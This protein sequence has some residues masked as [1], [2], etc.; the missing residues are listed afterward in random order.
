MKN[1][2]KFENLSLQLGSRKLF[3]LLNHSFEDKKITALLG[4]SGCGKSTWLKIIAG[5]ETRF[6]GRMINTAERI[7]FVFQEARLIPWLTVK[8]NI[9]LSLS[10]KNSEET[11]KQDAL[12]RVLR[13]VRLE[14]S[15]HLFPHQLSGGMKMRVS[16]ARALILQPDLVLFDEP[17]SALDEILKQKLQAE[18]RDLIRAENY[19]ALFVTHS[20]EE[21]VFLADEILILGP[22]SQIR[23]RHPVKLPGA[24]NHSLRSDQSYFQ[25]VNLVRKLLH[26]GQT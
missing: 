13:R 16:L 10:S 7:S 17:F 21:A 5:L 1:E 25:E 2:L 8:E 23:H 24:R 19:T 3:H 12:E 15:G 11:Q 6:T 18:T 9:L 14:N 20:V 22:D 26:E 4:P